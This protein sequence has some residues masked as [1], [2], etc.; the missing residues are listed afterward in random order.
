MEKYLEKLNIKE[1]KEYN[2]EEASVN[3]ICFY[4]SLFKNPGIKNKILLTPILF[5]KKNIFYEFDV[6]DIIKIEEIEKVTDSSGNLVTV[7]KLWIK[8]GSKAIKHE[9]FI[10]E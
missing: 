2:I 3:A 1:I 6:K 9:P 10:V 4:G 7:V 5:L 8:K